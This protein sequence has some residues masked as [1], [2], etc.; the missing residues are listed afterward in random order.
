MVKDIIKSAH[1]PNEVVAMLRLKFGGFDIKNYNEPLDQLAPKLGD[2][3]F[4]YAA[5]NKVSGDDQTVR[6]WSSTTGKEAVVFREVHSHYVC[7][8]TDGK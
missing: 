1:R 6:I 3:E 7:F 4:C 5:L 8:S 2:K